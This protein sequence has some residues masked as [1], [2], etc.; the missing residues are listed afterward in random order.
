MPINLTTW[1]GRDR[2][3]N[4]EETVNSLA[5][6]AGDATFESIDGDLVFKTSRVERG[7][8]KANGT[9][10]GVFVSPAFSVTDY[11]AVGDGVTDNT[12]AIQTAVN[13]IATAG[14]GTLFF[15]PG[16]YLAA[17]VVLPQAGFTNSFT[18][19]ATGAVLKINGAN[20]FFKR[21]APAQTTA[22]NTMIGGGQEWTFRGATF[23]GSNQAGQ[24]G[25]QI[26]A[27]YKLV[28]EKCQFINC[29]R[30]ININ[31]A[32]GAVIS[33][34]MFTNNVN[35]DLYVSYGAWTGSS[36]SASGSN[37]TVERD[38]RHYCTA[39]MLA[40]SY[41]GGSAGC[42]VEDSI[43][44]GGNPVNSI[45]VYYNATTTA[46]HFAVSNLHVEHK[47][48]NA[49][50]ACAIT[51]KLLV[52]QVWMQ[53]DS[54]WVD[55]TYST[56]YYGG[57][58]IQFT[59]CP[60]YPG[61]AGSYIGKQ[62]T[63]SDNITWTLWGFGG[64]DTNW[65]NATYWAGGVLPQKLA[66]NYRNAISYPNMYTNSLNN[67][68]TQ[69]QGLILGA[70]DVTTLAGDTVS[71]QNAAQTTTYFSTGPF[72]N[73]NI[74]FYGVTPV[75]R[76]GA[77]ADLRTSLVN[78]GLLTGGGA[79]PLNLNGGALTAG[80][81]SS[82]GAMTAQAALVQKRVAITYGATM[83]TD[84]SLGNKFVITA[85]DANAFTISNPTNPVDGQEITYT[86]RNGTAGALG[87]AT[88]GAAFKLAAWTQPAAGNSRSITFRYDGTNWVEIGRTPADVPN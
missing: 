78:V 24:Y 51:G 43:F 80:S 75:A 42:Q 61:G 87:A 38:C 52:D 59:N 67:L 5:P 79:T 58:D 13:A 71:L 37:A 28:I 2:F 53:Y 30:G 65:N 21:L 29:D 11:G 35:Y 57:L 70:S 34:C 3:R 72:G 66:V 62:A 36:A 17:N 83:A 8:I 20:P 76:P 14:G 50:I 77:T 9:K 88:W 49:I 41:F 40:G 19:E 45:V 23:T 4:I 46:K 64:V 82:T 6:S 33:G 81:V 15:P 74:G 32:L 26:D 63:A 84:A 73:P 54:I 12:T 55:T 48:T 1:N 22:L 39:G 56:G 16:T 85:T 68:R 86:I 60:Y 10:T 31:F 27:T 18:V 69:N 47:P 44:E 25:I 7:R